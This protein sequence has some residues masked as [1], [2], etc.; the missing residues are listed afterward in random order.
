MLFYYDAFDD[1]NFSLIES[2][3]GENHIRLIH[4][5]S[6]NDLIL[7]DETYHCGRMET[8]YIKLSLPVA[9][10]MFPHLTDK[11]PQD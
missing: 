3:K 1:D 2:W 7:V 5:K 8:Q 10:K 9:R 6:K 4:D 11:I